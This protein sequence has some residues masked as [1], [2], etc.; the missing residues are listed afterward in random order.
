MHIYIY[1]SYDSNHGGLPGLD[2]LYMYVAVSPNHDVEPRPVARSGS[3]LVFSLYRGWSQLVAKTCALL[4]HRTL[5]VVS[6][7]TGHKCC[8]CE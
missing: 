6:G 2:R 3:K 7:T 8:T 1:F 4:V 5:D